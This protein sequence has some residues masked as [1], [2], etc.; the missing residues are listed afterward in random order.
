MIASFALMGDLYQYDPYDTEAS[1]WNSYPW[2]IGE[3]NLVD[4]DAAIP[5]FSTMKTIWELDGGDGIGTTDA[6]LGN[7]VM[8]SI[9]ILLDNFG[10]VGDDAGNM[11]KPDPLPYKIITLMSGSVLSVASKTVLVEANSNSER[12]DE[13]I[14]PIS[15]IS[16]SI[17]SAASTLRIVDA[18]SNSE[19]QDEPVP[20]ISLIS[21]SVTHVSSKEII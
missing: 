13:P 15:L 14:K 18:S 6:S 2:Q 16:G 12:Q 4:F 20:L 19:R 21:G 7:F 5:E 9:L 10:N 3:E 17:L 11:P 8:F 1:L